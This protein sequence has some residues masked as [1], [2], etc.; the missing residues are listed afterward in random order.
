MDPMTAAILGRAALGGGQILGSLLTKAK[1]PKYEIPKSEREALAMAKLRAADPNMPGQQRAEDRAMLA[2]AN[3]VRG[4][5]DSGNAMEV[6][7]AISA[8]TQGNL[9]DISAQSAQFQNQ[10]LDRLD[11]ALS[12][13]AEYQD[14]EFQM[15]EFAPYAQKYELKQQLLGGGLEN[16]AKAGEQFVLNGGIQSPAELGSTASGNYP[17]SGMANFA[18]TGAKLG[19]MYK[20]WTP[21]ALPQP[22]IASPVPGMVGGMNKE[23]LAMLMRAIQM[24]M[25]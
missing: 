6:I 8:G 18:M 16:I 12:R 21:D 24:G 22:G 23:Q 19:S 3:A 17:G 9:A 20:N 5:Q 2:E 14:Q 4:A 11:S 10:D 25:N 7:P 13:N 1:R 15:N